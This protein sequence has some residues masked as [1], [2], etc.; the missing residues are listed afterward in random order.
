[1]DWK[2]A[3]SFMTRDPDWKRKLLLGGALFYPLP[4]LG[5]ILALGFRS[6]TGPRLVEGSEPVLPE[7]RGNLVTIFKR[8]LLA[9]FVILCHFSPFLACYWLFG[10]DS[11][12]DFT[13]HWREIAWFFVAIGMF[14]PAFLPTLPIAYALWFPWLHFSPGEMAVLAMLFVGAFFILPASFVQVG[15]YGNFRS[16]FRA[17]S[18]A[19]WAPW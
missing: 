3:L 18:A 17:V 13:L 7:W 10:L 11:T 14:P 12:A 1:M 16:A 2:A 5:W 8:G 9:V 19:C 4:P 6:L 15:L